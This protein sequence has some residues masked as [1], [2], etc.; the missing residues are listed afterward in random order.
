MA[1]ERAHAI[2]GERR[3][4]RREQHAPR[5]SARRGHRLDRRD[6]RLGPHHHAGAAAVRR[7]VDAAVLV[8]REVARVGERDAEEPGRDRLAEEARPEERVEHL[9]EQGDDLEVH[10]SVCSS[11]DLREDRTTIR[12]AATSTART[13]SGTMGTRRSSSPSWITRRSCAACMTSAT[14][15]SGAPASVTTSQPG[16]SARKYSPSARA[17]SSRAT[18][19][20]WPRIASAASRSATPS[21][22][23]S[24]APPLVGRADST[25]RSTPATNTRG[26]SNSAVDSAE[27]R[28]TLTSPRTPWARAMYP[29]SRSCTLFED[30]EDGAALLLGGGAPGAPRAARGRCGPGGR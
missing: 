13:N 1:A 19:T 12:R 11:A 21:K 15:P 23:T 29:T 24:T 26:T 9:R 8:G 4:G 5:R 20:R 14:R 6:Q 10:V 18:A 22:A 30:L 17:M 7:V 3:P 27:W 2:V 28:W 16:R 25:A